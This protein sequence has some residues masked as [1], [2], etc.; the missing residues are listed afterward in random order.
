MIWIGDWIDYVFRRPLP[1]ELGYLRWGLHRMCTTDDVETCRAV[2]RSYHFKI[3]LVAS[4]F[5]DEVSFPASTNFQHTLEDLN[6]RLVDTF[7]RSTEIEK[8]FLDQ[9]QNIENEISSQNREMLRIFELAGISDCYA[10]EFDWEGD[11]DMLKIN[12]G[13]KNVEI[14]RSCLTKPAIG[15]NLFS[16]LFE[17]KWDRYHAR[18][19]TGRIY[20]DL[21]EEWMRP[22]IDYLK[23]NRI[24]NNPINSVDVFLRKTIQAF[25]LDKKLVLTEFVPSVPWIGLESSKIFSRVL[26][27]ITGNECRRAS[28][29]AFPCIPTFFQHVYSTVRRFSKSGSLDADI[30][31]KP[32]LCLWGSFVIFL[33]WAQRPSVHH[34]RSFGIETSS[35]MRFYINDCEKKVNIASDLF[36]IR[37]TCNEVDYCINNLSC[38]QF[39]PLCTRR[40][41]QNPH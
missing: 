28:V 15:W 27:S 38:M 32:I 31:F 2:D 5:A 4:M 40:Q 36:P 1:S 21:K 11:D 16:C 26:G 25:S 29:D 24:A 35:S 14:Q 22:L 41:L 18:D 9:K 30:R 17:K 39:I 13:G 23:Y 8:L 34:V 12:F 10:E 20:V 37:F 19:K 33:S 7:S 3:K 6:T